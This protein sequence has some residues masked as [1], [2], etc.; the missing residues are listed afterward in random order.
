MLRLGGSL[1]HVI[2][3]PDVTAPEIMVLRAIHG[4]DA[5]VDIKPTRMDKTSHRAERERLENVYGQ[6]GP[7]GKP[8][9]GAKAIVDL[10]GPA[11]MGG[12]LPVSLP[13]DAPAEPV[14]GED[15]GERT[16]A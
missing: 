4:A 8:G 10:F 1:S 5:V 9:F 16:A 2:P 15:E 12:R 14:E 6:P 3:K 7:S 13:E 11:A